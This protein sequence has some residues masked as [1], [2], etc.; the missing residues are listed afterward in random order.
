MRHELAAQHFHKG[1]IFFRAVNAQAAVCGWLKEAQY[2]VG[3]VQGKPFFAALYIVDQALCLCF[4]GYD[5][6]GIADEE[7]AVTDRVDV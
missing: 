7:I 2:R 6:A 4:T 1:Y 5:V 3:P